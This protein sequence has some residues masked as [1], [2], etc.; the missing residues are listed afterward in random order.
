MDR[1]QMLAQ[2]VRDAIELLRWQ[3][4]SPLAADSWSQW[5]I[6]AIAALDDAAQQAPPR[7]MV[8]GDL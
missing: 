4:R 2:V 8:E 6:L 5:V 7:E 1:E 3:A